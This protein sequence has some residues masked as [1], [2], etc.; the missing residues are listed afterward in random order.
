MRIVYA[1]FDEV[2]SFKAASTHILANCR[3][4]MGRHDLTLLT[5]GDTPL[6]PQAGLRHIT[7]A[8]REKN[9]L[10]RG[11][12]FREFVRYRLRHIRPALFHFRTPW[13]GLLAGQTGLPSV[14]E[15][16]G[17]PSVEL[18]YLYRDAGPQ[19]LEV[20]RQWEQ[21]CLDHA[22]AIVCPSER[23]RTCLL[24][25]YRVRDPGRINVIPNGYDVAPTPSPATDGPLRACTWARCIPGKAYCGPCAPSPRCAAAGNWTFTAWANG[26]GCA[27]RRNA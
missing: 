20:L 16:N 4:V 24:S 1:S 14:Y 6:P 3:E 21:R 7:A 15:V 25:R 26:H 19:V 11:L 10:R 8:L 9:Y 17:L 18:P 12:A 27:G 23:I 22:S 2:P 13:E 5:L